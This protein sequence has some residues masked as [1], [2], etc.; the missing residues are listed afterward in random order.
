MSTESEL[1]EWQS[2]LADA[3][4]RVAECDRHIAELHARRQRELSAEAER[5]AE[6]ANGEGDSHDPGSKD[7]LFNP[8][9]YGKHRLRHD[10]VDVASKVAWYRLLLA[11]MNCRRAFR[12]TSSK[13][14]ARII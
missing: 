13:L 3:K 1:A 14:T 6:A 10:S 11:G 4:R 5:E 12:H 9:A 8:F 2:H 7:K